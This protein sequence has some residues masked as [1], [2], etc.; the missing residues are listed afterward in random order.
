[1]TD[2]EAIIKRR[3]LGDEPTVEQLDAL[4]LEVKASP[5][6]H[7]ADLLRTFSLSRERALLLDG[8]TLAR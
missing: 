3:A 2:E 6:P 4:I 7:V 5:P 1:M 8:R